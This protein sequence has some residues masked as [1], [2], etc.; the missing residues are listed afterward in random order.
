M[1]SQKRISPVVPPPFAP[2]RI[3]QKFNAKLLADGIDC[4][5][6]RRII[7]KY[8]SYVGH[9]KD[10]SV[11][12]FLVTDLMREVNQLSRL[13]VF[14]TDGNRFNPDRWPVMQ[15]SLGALARIVEQKPEIMDSGE[16]DKWTKKIRETTLNYWNE[17]NI[18][19]AKKHLAE[20]RQK[21]KITSNPKDQL[22]ARYDEFRRKIEGIVKGDGAAG[23]IL[24]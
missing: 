11:C 1:A 9:V 5:I 3:V 20:L 15:I 4:T 21:K 17:Q 19:L 23:G 2:V 22:N 16:M 7:D 14:G 8:G 12:A 6:Q 10:I 13:R 18:P 24:G